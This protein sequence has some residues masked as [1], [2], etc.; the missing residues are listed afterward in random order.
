MFMDRLT[1]FPAFPS[2]GR[3][4]RPAAVEAAS[5]SVDNRRASP[6]HSGIRARGCVA[7]RFA[8]GA[9]AGN[10]GG[11]IG[12]GGIGESWTLTL[13]SPIWGVPLLNVPMK[14]ISALNEIQVQHI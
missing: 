1:D 4:A 9:L 2:A 10:F 8:S 14:V 11:V 3:R 5:P 12:T 6:G 7:A 13:Q